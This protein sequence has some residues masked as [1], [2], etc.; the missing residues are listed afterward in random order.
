MLLAP[1]VR[2]EGFDYYARAELGGGCVGAP[3]SLESTHGSEGASSF[4]GQYNWAVQVGKQPLDTTGF[5]VA[6]RAFRFYSK[7]GIPISKQRVFSVGPYVEFCGGNCGTL[8]FGTGL[9]LAR[10][11]L[12][13]D[14]GAI[15]E[16]ADGSASI[17][18]L[19]A[20]AFMYFVGGVAVL[21]EAVPAMDMMDH[22]QNRGKHGASITFGHHLGVLQAWT[23]SKEVAVN[24]TAWYTGMYV[25]LAVF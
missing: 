7:T 23:S 21:G 20:G 16:Q 24:A 15:G 17:G 8:A 12:N 22:K 25:G 13:I 9:G 10:W 6:F 5:G 18:M 14:S 2:A 4:V 3:V 1:I 19:G 11:S